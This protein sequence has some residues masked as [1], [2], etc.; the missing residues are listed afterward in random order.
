MRFM[1]IIKATPESEAGILPS[2][3]QFAAMGRF[4]DEMT[5]AGVMLSG[6]G[7]QPSSDGARV[8]YT[9][10]KV[11]VVDG[12]FTESKELIAGFWI[13]QTGSLQ[14]A[15]DWIKRVPFE[16]FGVDGDIEIRRIAEGEDIGSGQPSKQPG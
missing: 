1:A 6:E 14:E 12:P 9:R 11:S 7:L 8:R 15:V 16:A 5:K 2:A 3:E 4:N 13:L 10:G